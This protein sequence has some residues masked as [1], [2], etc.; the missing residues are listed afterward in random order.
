MDRWT[1]RLKNQ[2]DTWL[3]LGK[4]NTLSRGRRLDTVTTGRHHLRWEEDGFSARR[5]AGERRPLF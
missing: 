4:S 1:D 5:Q 2:R 3:G